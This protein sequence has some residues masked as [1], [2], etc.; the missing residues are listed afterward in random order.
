MSIRHM[1]MVLWCRNGAAG[2]ESSL[3]EID[4]QV[5]DSI[6]PSPRLVPFCVFGQLTPHWLFWAQSLSQSPKGTIRR[7]TGGWRISD[8]LHMTTEKPSISVYHKIVASTYALVLFLMCWLFITG[9]K[10]LLLGA[11]GSRRCENSTAALQV[12]QAQKIIMPSA[13]MRG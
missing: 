1:L 3:R 8:C 6:S 11:P 10:R 7:V 4:A 12:L 9:R 2:D 13:T 5:S